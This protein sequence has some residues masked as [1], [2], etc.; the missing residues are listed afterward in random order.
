MFYDMAM[1]VD[2]Q[3]EM[4]D[5]IEHNVEIAAVHI[6]AGQ[7]EI[8]VAVQFQRKH[9]KVKVTCICVTNTA[10]TSCF[11][12]YTDACCS[13]IPETATYYAS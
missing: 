5:R 9:R 13:D 11:Q 12:F 7:K 8:R 6:D 3:G 10:C 1:L 2:Q 4:L